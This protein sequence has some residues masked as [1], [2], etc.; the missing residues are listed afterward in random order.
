MD[1]K[2]LRDKMLLTYSTT[3]GNRII[4]SGTNENKDT[5]YVELK[6]IDR[7][8]IIPPPVIVSGSY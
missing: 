3:D 8:F 4:L 2:L 7:G 6:R 1:P 5:L